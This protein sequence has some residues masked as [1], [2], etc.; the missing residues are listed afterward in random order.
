MVKAV[1]ESLKL[2]DGGDKTRLGDLIV[3]QIGLAGGDT[4]AARKQ[5]EKAFSEQKAMQ[6]DFGLQSLAGMAAPGGR[7]SDGG[8]DALA[9]S[10]PELADQIKKW[11]EAESKD[12]SPF[13][14]ANDLKKF[15]TELNSVVKTVDGML[16]DDERKADPDSA[17][18]VQEKALSLMLEYPKD[19]DRALALA[20][21]Q[22]DVDRF[23]E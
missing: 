19:T 9:K 18:K 11:A 22:R 2:Q 7:A 4:E 14:M 5:V 10:N 12:K 13:A 20:K 6:Y 8:F 3:K 23:H 1:Q 16:T 15:Q 21:L 17:R